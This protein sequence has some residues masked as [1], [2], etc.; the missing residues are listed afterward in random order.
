MKNP[1]LFHFLL[2]PGILREPLAHNDPLILWFPDKPGSKFQ[3][4]TRIS[5]VPR[6]VVNRQ[7]DIFTTTATAIR[8]RQRLPV[9]W[10]KLL[11]LF[12]P[13]AS[14]SGWIH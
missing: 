14:D 11:G 1:E 9:F 8:T 7:E 12:H 10:G 6:A 3:F 13:L 5:T 2:S 4:W